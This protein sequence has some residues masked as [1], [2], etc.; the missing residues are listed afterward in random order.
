MSAPA[1]DLKPPVEGATPMMAQYLEVKAQAGGALLFYRMGDFYELF[2]EDAEKAAAA[3]DIALTR[4]GKH[5]GKDVAM[6]GVPVHAAE[7]YLARLIRKNFRVAVC[8][9][10][11]D[12]KE[13][14]KRGSK[15]VVKRE[16]VRI[17][18]PG[19]ITED[20]LLDSRAANYV[21][22]YAKLPSGEAALAWADVSTGE[23]ACAPVETGSLAADL[24][25]L[26]PAELVVE[27]SIAGAPWLKSALRGGAAAVTPLPA[28][29]FDPGAGA[30]RLKAHYGLAALDGLGD[31]SRAE[32]AAA[33]AL[34]DYLQLTQAGRAPALAPLS[35]RAAGAFMAI[36]PA[37]RA[38]LEIERTQ[39]GERKGSLLAAIDRTVTG[40]G[41]RLL[42][43]RLAA[44]LLNAGEIEARLDA[45]GFF[46]DQQALRRDVRARLR[47]TG[48][49]ARALSRLQL[50]RGGPRDLAMLA[51][52]LRA[53]E[54]VCAL[55]AETPLARPP[56]ELEQALAA[57]SLTGKPVLAAFAKNLEKALKPEPPARASDGDFIAQGW[58]ETLDEARALRD[59]ARRVIAGLQA[60]YAEQT[61]IPA[62]KIRHNNVLG[63]FIECTAKAGEKLM[64]APLN[65]T[66]RHRQTMANAVR[67]ST[68]ELG[69]LESKILGAAERALAMELQAFEE[70][71]ARADACEREIRAGAEA[72]AVLDV[73][74]GL[75]ETAESARLA[76]P[77]VDDSL[78]FEIEGGRHPVVEQALAAESNAFTPNDCRLDGAAESGPRLFLVTGP[79]MAGKSTFLRQNA[80]IAILA[81]T[82]C[83]VPA[84]AARIGMVDRLFSRVG[85]SD[86][87]A[88]GRSTFMIEMIETA[89]ILNQA[90]PRAFVILDEIGRGTATFDGM[91]IAWATAEHLLAVNRCRALFATHYHELTE[92]AE[93]DPAGAN[94]SLKARE[95]KGDLVFL[96]EVGPGAADKSYGV[97]VG[98][99]AG[100]PAAVTRR[101]EEVLARLEGDSR[102][103]ALDSLPLFAPAAGP[104]GP[105]PAPPS[106]VETALGEIDPDSLSPRDALE[107]L[108]RLK[109][110][111]TET[112]Q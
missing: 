97:Q 45:V 67:F 95:W 30:D 92:L 56:A 63:Y 110:I 93:R 66:F 103:D 9:Q 47:E 108:Y 29:K 58:L 15:S 88:R 86:D 109:R 49:A 69:E 60:K 8:E 65:E 91:A 57:L 61:G 3:L 75:A 40:P 104:A 102:H 71:R 33:G 11:E 55:F 7:T 99:L 90:G 36:D 112:G 100:L 22:A 24:A 85:A 4:R 46:L 27:D 68:V 53:G 98:R 35:R 84:R 44:P 32:R 31:F 77:V 37:T 106:P 41:A 10:V 80:L 28:V 2:F 76:R 17:V 16:I 70:F 42:A 107:A 5:A 26:A 43:R 101:A 14:K 79:N 78:A 94:V 20:A 111:A 21:A 59:E 82:G 1:P 81:Q 54:T 13:A 62:L 74:S 89:A 19:T 25:A 52:A 39:R 105:L 72:L 38:S 18:T 83:Y 96:H 48:D 50:G 73:A 64:T 12:P 34:L 87:L 6:C 23:F 51:A